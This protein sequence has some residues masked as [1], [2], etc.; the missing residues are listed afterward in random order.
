[1]RVGLIL[2]RWDPARGGAE[3]ALAKLAARLTAR[4]DEPCV[5]TLAFAPG[6]PGIPHVLPRPRRLRGAMEVAFARAAV[7]AARDAR[8]DVT[9]GV[10]HLEEVDVY[11]PHGGLHR[12]TLAAGE[13]A[14]GGVAGD[15]ARALHRLSPKHRTFLRLEEGLLARGGARAVWC[16]SRLVRDEI[17]SAFPASAPRLEVHANGVDLARF[18]P[19]IRDERR[20]A[21][22]A[23]HRIDPAAPVIVFPGGN[24]RLKGWD[25]ALR[26]LVDVPAPWTLVATGDRGD[27]LAAPRALPG[28][29]V[30]L[31][32]QDAFDLYAAADLVLQPTFRDPCSLATLEALACGVPVVTTSA[33]GAADAVLRADPSAVVAPGDASAL[34]AAVAA[35]LRPS[36]GA[37]RAARDS[38]ADRPEDAWLAALARALAAVA[39]TS[40]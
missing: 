11:W 31:P 39:A 30:R 23:R 29:V 3:R 9:L 14:R 22:V 4:G 26:A 10:R 32:R 27:R 36:P 8:C 37:R 6:A 16:V 20:A 17:V 34:A 25:V 7:R 28:R 21:F 24:W 35:R 2:D 33:N 13:R 38:V 19:Q 5:F 1:M 18:R 15:V 12:A 40:S